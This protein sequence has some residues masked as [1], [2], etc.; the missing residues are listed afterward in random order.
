[1]LW[2]DEDDVDSVAPEPVVLTEI[3]E[4]EG[5]EVDAGVTV[6]PMSRKMTLLFSLLN[7]KN[8]VVRQGV[9]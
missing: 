5:E 4:R 1:M 8:S 9:V 3:F 2:R 7:L 6:H